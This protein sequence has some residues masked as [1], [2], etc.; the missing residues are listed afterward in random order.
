[1]I[2]TKPICVLQTLQYVERT[3]PECV[4][5]VGEHLNAPFH[6]P[7]AQLPCR[8]EDAVKDSMLVQQSDEFG[9]LASHSSDT[10]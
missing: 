6:A 2:Q 5:N 8:T 7:T 10:R 1:M 3:S 9:Y 4:L